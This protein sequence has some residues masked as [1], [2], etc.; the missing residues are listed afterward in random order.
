M[1]TARSN[2]F[3][4]SYEVA[5]DGPPLVL[6]PG[7]FQDGAH[8]THSGYTSSLTP[9]YTVI[10]IDP[11]GLG[12]SDAPREAEAYALERRVAS[13]TAVL[14]DVGAGR[15]AFWGYS[16]GAMTGYAVAALAPDRLTCLVAGAWD[17]IDGF[18]SAIEPTL[19]QWGLPADTD[20]YA[21]IKQGA[22]AEPYQAALIDSGDPGAFRANYEAFSREPGLHAEL[23]ASGVPMLLYAGTVDPWHEPMHAFA[24]RTGVAA[25]FS[26]PD[27]DHKGGWDRSEDV[28][29]QV[30]PFL[31]AGT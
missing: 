22:A 18:H 16:L 10:A 5:G 23:A 27:A 31:A 12:A 20:P 21:L 29:P 4:I 28:L 26:L 17:P 8:W 13:V 14:D 24:G 15:A 3:K 9:A 7:M 6:H 2:G 19:R 1:P 30:L 11:L 25:F